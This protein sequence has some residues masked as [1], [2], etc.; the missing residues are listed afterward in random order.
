MQVVKGDI[1]DAKEDYILQ[2]CNCLTV[3]AHGL[4]ADLARKFPYADI[5]ATRRPIGNRN[6]CIEEDRSTP[7][8]YEIL[9]DPEETSPAIICLFGQWRPGAVE[10]S[11]FKQYPESNPPESKE[12]REYWFKVGLFRI[13]EYFR[14]IISDKINTIAVPYKIGCG[15]AKGDW[16][17][18]LKMLTDFQDRY[19]DVI[20]LILYM[21]EGS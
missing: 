5:Y 19:R 20:Q 18:Y 12:A 17:T 16:D 13:G 11:Y 10:T 8:S 15:L 14:V 7:G 2:Q 9:S 21:R 4:S 1:L 3:R 6:V